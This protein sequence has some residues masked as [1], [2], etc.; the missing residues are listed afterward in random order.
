MPRPPKVNPDA[1]KSD[2][3]ELAHRT[4]S[5]GDGRNITFTE[6]EIATRGMD[7][8]VEKAYGPNPEGWY[9]SKYAWL[10]HHAA[11]LRE[12]LGME[13]K[14]S[15]DEKPSQAIP[16]SFSDFWRKTQ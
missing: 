15:I 3:K 13:P 9:M 8:L 1:S 12:A 11:F 2:T 4:I 16:S 14:P 6:E 10:V 5:I 7:Y